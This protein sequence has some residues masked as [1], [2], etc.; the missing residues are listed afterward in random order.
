MTPSTQAATTPPVATIL[1]AGHVPHCGETR[2]Y[3]MVV[4]FKSK[5]EFKRAMKDK[6]VTITAFSHDE[7][8][9]ME[10]AGR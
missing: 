1:D 3:T 10:E 5:D 4:Q 7:Y 2:P 9:E 6:V 8:D